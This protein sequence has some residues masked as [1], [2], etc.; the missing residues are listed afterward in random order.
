MMHL[1]PMTCEPTRSSPR[2]AIWKSGF[3][4]RREVLRD[5]GPGGLSRL[6]RRKK[7]SPP[8]V[9]RNFTASIQSGNVHGTQVTTTNK[10]MN[11]GH[12]RVKVKS[13]MGSINLCSPRSFRVKNLADPSSKAPVRSIFSHADE[14]VVLWGRRWGPWFSCARGAGSNGNETTVSV[15]VD[16]KPWVP[17]E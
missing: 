11:V 12:M 10:N 9:F 3:I 1:A 4:F 17:E 5:S 6:W 13:L 8:S 15:A 16:N 14:P 2:C 7:V